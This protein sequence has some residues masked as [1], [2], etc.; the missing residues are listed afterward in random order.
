MEYAELVP[1]IRELMVA[2]IEATTIY[3]TIVSGYLIVAYTSAKNLSKF[4]VG[5]VTLLFLGFS[6]FFT[7]AAYAFFIRADNLSLQWGSDAY[8]GINQ[9]YAYILGSMQLLGIV[10]SLYFMLHSRKI[11]NADT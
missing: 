10:G 8:S 7:Y 9:T 5:L 2:V 6:L 1:E 4:Q 11:K 3:L